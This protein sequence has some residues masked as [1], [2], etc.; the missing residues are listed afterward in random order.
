MKVV[1]SF[2]PGAGLYGISLLDTLLFHMRG[3]APLENFLK[4]GKFVLFL[5]NTTLVKEYNFISGGF[6][7]CPGHNY[8]FSRVRADNGT[9]DFCRGR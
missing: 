8:F 9:K 3:H 5:V 7:Q 1:L 2:I 6:Y 4:N